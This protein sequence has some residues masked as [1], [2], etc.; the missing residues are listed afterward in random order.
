MIKLLL[1]RSEG[2]LDI[3]VVDEH[4]RV[5]ID[6]AFKMNL[7]LERVAVQSRALMAARHVR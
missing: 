6:R 3:G 1:E 4:A 2:G 7:E 5:R